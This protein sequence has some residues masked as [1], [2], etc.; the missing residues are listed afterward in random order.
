MSPPT[1]LNRFAPIFAVADLQ[2]A[3]AHYGSLGFATFALEEGDDYAF[4]ERDGVGLHLSAAADHEPSAD[5]GEA[6]LHVE[7]ADAFSRNGAG[8]E[9]PAGPGRQ[10]DT[11]YQLRE[12]SHVD[13]D[14]NLIRF[15]SPLPQ[16]RVQSHLVSRYGIGVTE[17][18]R[19]DAGV[20]LFRRSDGPAGW[21]D[22]SRRHGR[23]RPPGAMPTCCASWPRRI[24]PPNAWPRRIR[25]RSSM[26]RASW[27]PSTSNRSRKKN[28]GR[29]SRI[30]ADSATS[31][32]CSGG[33]TH[34]PMGRGRPP[35]RAGLGTTWPTAVRPKRSRR[36]SGCSTPPQRGCRP[37]IGSSVP[38]CGGSSTP[39]TA[40]SACRER[41]STRTSSWP[42]WLPPLQ[43]APLRRRGRRARDREGRAPHG[44]PGQGPADRAR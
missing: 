31:V 5:G 14:G 18:T 15:G 12:G 16:V 35:V 19:L 43:A 6:Y 38:R 41:S 27:S 22:G 21:P 44:A 4:A 9:S 37:R 8:P 26:G 17:A 23:R 29:R 25:C 1:R 2:R 32:Q 7:D 24:F 20:F 30:A 13:P 10:G 40:T 33:C 34:C 42:T 28:G 39:S 11:P 3:L 36:P